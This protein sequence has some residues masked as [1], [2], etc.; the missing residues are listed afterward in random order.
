M[1]SQ[2]LPVYTGRNK[3]W[4]LLLNFENDVF[5]KATQNIR[6]NTGYQYLA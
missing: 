6:T 2:G 4:L 1:F 3:Y 5:R